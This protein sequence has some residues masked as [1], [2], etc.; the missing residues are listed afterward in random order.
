MIVK[1]APF[2]RSLFNAAVA[3]EGMLVADVLQIWLDVSSSPARGE[4]QADLLRRKV[5]EKVIGG[6]R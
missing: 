3:R 4:E 2:P 6:A 1:Q 5:L